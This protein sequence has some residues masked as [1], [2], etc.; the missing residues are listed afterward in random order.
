MTANGKK[1]TFTAFPHIAMDDPSIRPG[2]ARCRKRQYPAPDFMRAS[3]ATG[4]DDMTAAGTSPSPSF[5]IWGW[6]GLCIAVLAGLAPLAASPCVARV[7]D[8]A[9][10]P[11]PCMG[12]Q[13]EPQVEITLLFG[14]HR[15]DGGGRITTREWNTF[16]REVVT[17]R[18]PAGLTVLRG[19]GQWQNRVSGR[20]GREPS[21]IV[22]IVTPPAPD[23]QARLDT[24]RQV[25]RQRFAQQSV[26]LV[27]TA[28]C[29]AF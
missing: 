11:V 29:A 17:P 6:R 7:P 23:L 4:T 10:Q 16:M 3:A 22:W 13:A 19:D 9:A 18:F 21:R 15:P 24:I 28:G 8:A 12:L 26:G 1:G 2:L 5:S 27:V 20:V 25:Y 14:Q